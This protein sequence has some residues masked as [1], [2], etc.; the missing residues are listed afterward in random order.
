MVNLCLKIILSHDFAQQFSFRLSSTLSVKNLISW[1]SRLH[2]RRRLDRQQG[3]YLT[4]KFSDGQLFAIVIF[5]STSQHSR[6]VLYQ[7]SLMLN[8]LEC[9]WPIK[10]QTQDFTIT[11]IKPRLIPSSHQCHNNSTLIFALMHVCI[12][13]IHRMKDIDD[14]SINCIRISIIH[15]P[16]R[17]TKQLMQIS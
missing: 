9:Q 8:K 13:S 15:L 5:Y 14:I 10:D 17:S 1:F 6:T 16:I 7:I 3:L 2:Y 12:V 4:L 11:A